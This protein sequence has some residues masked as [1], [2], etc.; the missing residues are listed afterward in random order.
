MFASPDMYEMLKSKYGGRFDRWITDVKRIATFIEKNKIRAV[1]RVHLLMDEP[2]PV[3]QPKGSKATME[4]AFIRP[5]YPPF[6]GGLK[7]AHLH[8]RGDIYLLTDKQ[9]KEYSGVVVRDLQKKLGAAE[10]V[11]FDNLM[12]IS[13]AIG[14]LG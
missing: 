13:E 8:F 3:I 12:E 7:C 4:V 10:T 9:W 1:E 5:P 6:P 2:A 11:S 14:G